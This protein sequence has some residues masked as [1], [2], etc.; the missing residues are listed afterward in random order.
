MRLIH[1]SERLKFD[2]SVSIQEDLYELIELDYASRERGKLSGK[3][4][5]SVRLKG[6][7]GRSM[8]SRR[9]ASVVNHGQ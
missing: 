4:T 9:P 3:K 2:P 8:R 5:S 6:A 7:R 1:V